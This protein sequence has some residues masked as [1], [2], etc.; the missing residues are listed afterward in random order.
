VR[1][2]LVI[3]A[4]AVGSAASHAAV[5]DGLATLAAAL[6][7][8]PADRD[9]CLAVQLHVTEVD[10]RPIATAGW[11]AAELAA[12]NRHFAPLSIGFGVVGVDALPASG[13]H[14]AGREDRDAIG[15]GRLVGAVLHV[16]IV[17]QLDDIDEPGSVIRGVTWHLPDD[18]R[19]YVLVSTA[20]PER[21]LAHELGHVFGL[22]HSTYAISI[23]NKTPR[24]DPPDDQRR[25]ADAELAAM[26]PVRARLVRAGW[27]S[28][29]AR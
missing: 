22:P 3:A 27:A 21:T 25:F 17:G 28:E 12:A 15:R 19:K 18:A 29:L 9:H 2:A 5:D 4:M 8:C 24:A 13:D 1:R 14:I 6:P 7:G 20:A 23:M 26:R 10:D 16:F 11:L